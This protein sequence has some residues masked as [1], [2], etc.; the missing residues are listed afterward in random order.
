MNI[1]VGA[2]NTQGFKNT[3]KGKESKELKSYF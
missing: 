1:V 2:A 3:N